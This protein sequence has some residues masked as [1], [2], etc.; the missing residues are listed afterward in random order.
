[1]GNLNLSPCKCPA[2]GSSERI[3]LDFEAVDRRYVLGIDENGTTIIDE[4]EFDTI[5]E[6][7]AIGFWCLTCDHEW[8]FGDGNYETGAAYDVEMIVATPLAPPGEGEMSSSVST[9]TAQKTG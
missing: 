2:C 8:K 9:T 1:M 4:N 7:A 3:A 6:G 5:A